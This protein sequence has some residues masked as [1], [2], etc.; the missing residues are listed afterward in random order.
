MSNEELCCSFC[1]KPKSR[2]KVLI[3][4]PNGLA[5]C[6]ECVQICSE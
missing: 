4:G 2:T 6:D 5:I 1:G 3:T